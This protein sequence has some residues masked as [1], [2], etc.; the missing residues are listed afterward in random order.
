MQ[1][2]PLRCTYKGSGSCLT[3]R[4][5]R[6]LRIHTSDRWPMEKHTGYLRSIFLSQTL[7][8]ASKQRPAVLEPKHKVGQHMRVVAHEFLRCARADQP[9]LSSVSFASLV[10]SECDTTVV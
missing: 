3:V 5:V 9:F 2:G 6:W 8:G 4:I 10:L 7:A 1:T